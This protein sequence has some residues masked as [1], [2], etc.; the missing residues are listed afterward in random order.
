MDRVSSG[1]RVESFHRNDE[2]SV[3][4]RRDVDG[5]TTPTCFVPVRDRRLERDREGERDRPDL[6]WWGGTGGRV[7][8]ESSFVTNG[9]FLK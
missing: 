6:T 4:V 8:V 5:N 9:Q 2:S 7:V 3:T 1:T